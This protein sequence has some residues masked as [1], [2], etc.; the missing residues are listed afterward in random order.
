VPEVL[1]EFYIEQMQATGC[2]L[3][4]DHSHP[5]VETGFLVVPPQ[6][7][8]SRPETSCYVAIR[9]GGGIDDRSL[10]RRSISEHDD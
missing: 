4:L 10:T 3:D 9:T 1:V 6:R 2:S 7:Y 5:L 8:F